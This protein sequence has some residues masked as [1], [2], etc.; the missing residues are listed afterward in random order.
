MWIGLVFLVMSFVTFFVYY[1]DKQAAINGRRRVSEKTLWTLGFCCGWPGGLLA[2]RWLRHKSS[3]SSFLILFTITVIG[4][5][6]CVFALIW[7][8][9]RF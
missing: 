3:K 7:Y 9:L 4:N 8:G 1:L 6:A 2:Q 5:I